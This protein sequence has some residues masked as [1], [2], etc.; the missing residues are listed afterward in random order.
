MNAK[1]DKKRQTSVDQWGG[2]YHIYIYI[3]VVYVFFWGGGGR[4]RQLRPHYLS[5]R[6]HDLWGPNEPSTWDPTSHT[7]IIPF[8]GI[9]A[10]NPFEF[11][12]LHF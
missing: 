11:I 8:V 6:V 7:A 10:L 4:K 12:T 3:Y 2:E 1:N 9:W 5:M